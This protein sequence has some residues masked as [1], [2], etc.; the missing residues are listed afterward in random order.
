M[1]PG[2]RIKKM[3]PNSAPMF[4]IYGSPGRGKTT[5]ASEFPNPI[6]IQ[7]ENGGNSKIGPDTFG[8]MKT[9]D[10]LLECLRWIIDR[11]N[12]H[13][14]QTLVIDS[15]GDLDRLLEPYVCRKNK[16][17]DK[18]GKEDLSIG[19]KQF[20]KG[21]GAIRSEWPKFIQ[22]LISINERRG[23]MIVATCHDVVEKFND[24]VGESY[25]YHALAIN[26]KVEEGVVGKFD[27]VL[28]L[29]QDTAIMSGKSTGKNIFIHCNTSP[30][31]T[32]KN[33]SGMP[34]KFK[35]TIGKGFEEISKYLPNKQVSFETKE[36]SEEKAKEILNDEMD[37]KHDHLNE[38]IDEDSQQEDGE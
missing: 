38:L 18:E 12:D 26:K 33:R 34:D 1:D 25:D 4:L 7:L 24:P 29:R 11:K 15:L 14:Y 13:G 23:M 9:Y 22:N 17:F 10:E 6:F 37:P 35:F 27:N 16:W 2:S 3:E 32:A 28:F 5:L 21:Y 20:N 31:F 30:S 19:N 36:L 8:V